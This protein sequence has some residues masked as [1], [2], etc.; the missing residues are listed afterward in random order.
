MKIPASIR[1]AYDDQLNKYERLKAKVDIGVR[2]FS[3]PRWHYESRV[4][5]LPSY[6][7]KLETG[8]FKNPSA[9]EDFFACTLVVANLAEVSEAEALICLNFEL[10]KRRPAAANR[11]HK[12]PEEFAFDDLRL[13]VAIRPDPML[14]PSD[15]DGVEFEFQVKTFLQHAWSIA[16]HDLVYKTDDVNWSKQR[17]AYQA[18]AVLEHAEI[19]IQEAETLAASTALAMESDSVRD[20]K[21]TIGILRE[22]W[23][24]EQLPTDLRR[25]AENVLNLLKELKQGP[26]RLTTILD[27]GKSAAGMHPS[28]LS[29][30][31]TVVQYLLSAQDD[32]FLRHLLRRDSKNPVLIPAEIVLPPGIDRSTW[33]NAIAIG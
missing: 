3:K 32:A 27:N 21:R 12:K 14:P 1:N 30:F 13:F 24:A 25:L 5:A 19:S 18:K 16:T 17:I 15:L 9:L 23:S 10:K 28:N 11:T 20:L 29:P 22:Q 8:R 6:A 31:G 33:T 2:A 7:L 26:D 4:K